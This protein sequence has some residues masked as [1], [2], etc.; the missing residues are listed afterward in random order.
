M[1]NQSIGIAIAG[2]GFGQKVHIPGFHA[3]P[4]THIV[5]V[6]HRDLNKA[7]AIA[8]NHNIPYSFDSI[9]DVISH[10][11]VE[12]VAVSTPPFLHYEMSKQILSAGKHLL[13]EKPVTINVKE[14]EELQKI[15]QKTGAITAIDFEFRFV[16][17][18]LLFEEYLQENYVGQKRFIKIDWLVSSRADST[19]PYNWYSRQDQGGGMLGAVGSHAFD[20]INWLFGKVKRLNCHLSTTIPQRPDPQTGELKTVDADDTCSL[21]LELIDGTPVQICFSSVTYNGRGHWVEVYGD[22]GTLILGNDN[23]KDYIHGFKLFAS[24]VGKNLTEIQVPNRLIFPQNYADGRIAPFI[25]VVDEW[26]KGILTKTEIIPSLK[27]GI[28]SQLLMDYSHQ[29]NQQ[30]MWVNL[31]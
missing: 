6:Y 15:A 3:H 11:E 20:Y 29:S 25:R 16:P 30:N 31:Y 5:A 2:T 23:Q 28:Y 21:M 27:E 4:N 1:N 7:K 18:W 14:A 26:V 24:S 9:N 17:S 12:G 13:L 8:K 22:Q 19:R 10:P